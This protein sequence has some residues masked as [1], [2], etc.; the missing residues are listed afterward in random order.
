MSRGRQLRTG[1]RR[2]EQGCD[3]RRGLLFQG[4]DGVRVQVEGNTDVGMSKAL[5]DYLR[6]NPRLQR[7]GGVCVSEVMEA[8][9]RLL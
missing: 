6:M 2:H 4:R 9:S 7:K 8:D 3:L 5:A 1:L